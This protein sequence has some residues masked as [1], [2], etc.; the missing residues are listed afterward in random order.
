MEFLMNAIQ[1]LLN[2]IKQEIPPQIIER[3]F[4]PQVIRSVR[5]A[6]PAYGFQFANSIDAQLIDKIIEGRLRPDLDYAG[7]TSV[8]ISLDGLAHQEL[9]SP[10]AYEGRFNVIYQI[11]KSRTNGLE[12]TAVHAFIYGINSQVGSTSYSG[13]QWPYTTA[14]STIIQQGMQGML[15]AVSPI[16]ISQ[17]ANTTIIGP[18]TI[19]ITDWTPLVRNGYMSVLLGYDSQF[20]TIPSKYY[21]ALSKLAIL[22]TKAWI[23]NNYLLEMGEQELFY[24]MTL[25][26]FTSIIERYE[27][28]N[29]LYAEYL[30]TQWK[31][32]ALL[33]DPKSAMKHYRMLIAGGQ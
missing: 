28:A 20:A 16:P 9:D 19:L 30:A 24:G 17:S 10:F 33:A 25:D 12:I 21:H 6:A 3:V 32:M 15:N 1:Y 23:Y 14:N 31:A 11:P 26:R 7:G 18:N 22:A 5:Q 27:D 4:A 13:G 8:D 29:D 2:R